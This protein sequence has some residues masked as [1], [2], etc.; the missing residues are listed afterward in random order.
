MVNKLLSDA[1]Q[2]RIKEAVQAAEQTTGAEI[3][4]VVVRRSSAIGHLP[5]LLALMILI[6]FMEV[7]TTLGAPL[8]AWHPWSFLVYAL[9]AM[10]IGAVLAK[11]PWLQRALTPNED[12]A[13]Q[14]AERASLEFYLAK[15]KFPSENPVILIF[16]SL[17]EHRA[18][19]L[20]DPNLNEHITGEHWQ[21]VV[22][23][24]IPDLRKGR[25]ADAIISGITAANAI[26]PKAA[27]RDAPGG[28]QI[29][30]H[31]IVK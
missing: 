11:W 14:V 17:M 16:L 28:N 20:A 10:I 21:R 12:E 24:I 23:Q 26:I 27:R 4:P 30:D 19:V 25:I 22:D 3:L 2:K 15:Q 9:I 1:D 18:V 7:D 5:L 29:P 8:H 6:V 13:R 31:V